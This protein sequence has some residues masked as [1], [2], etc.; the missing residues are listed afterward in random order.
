MK[1]SITVTPGYI[2]RVIEEEKKVLEEHN[3]YR[4]ALLIEGKR[5]RTEGYTREQIN[6]S[7]LQIIL[8]LGGGFGETFKA[9]IAR[10]LLGAIGIGDGLIS[11]V[12]VNVVENADI[13]D[14]KKYFSVNGCGELADL[15]VESLGETGAEVLVNPLMA[16]LGIDPSSRM[17]ATVRESLT[18][19]LFRD[20]EISNSIKDEIKEF[21]CKVEVDDV[22]GSFRRT[23]MGTSG[24]DGMVRNV[25]VAE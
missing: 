12:V 18:N 3:R 6:E 2:R 13:M 11:Q 4:R 14:F 1:N 23:V 25:A 20:S 15:I 9:D 5:L 16:T 10:A 17:Y 8:G 19:T 21:V 24:G 22:Y 7:L